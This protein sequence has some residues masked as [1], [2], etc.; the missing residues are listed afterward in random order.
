MPQMTQRR[1]IPLRRSRFRQKLL[2]YASDAALTGLQIIFLFSFFHDSFA[3]KTV[4]YAFATFL[5]VWGS[6]P[7]L[8]SFLGRNQAAP[9][10]LAVFQRALPSVLLLGWGESHLLNSS[11]IPF[12]RF[13][14]AIWLI[15]VAVGLFFGGVRAVHRARLRQAQRNI[16]EYEDLMVVPQTD[17]VSGTTVSPYYTSA[18]STSNTVPAEQEAVIAGRL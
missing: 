16:A 2:P 9:F 1:R 6:I 12:N 13:A 3:I 7:L 10:S 11:Y 18:F 4:L 14:V 15:Y 5:G 17:H 8:R